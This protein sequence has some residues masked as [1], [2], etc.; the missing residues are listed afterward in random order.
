MTLAFAL[1]LACGG[2]QASSDG[3]ETGGTGGTSGTEDTS[4]TG[5][6]TTEDGS[7]SFTTSESE[8]TTE[9]MKFDVGGIP[10]VKMVMTACPVDLGETATTNGSTPFGPY[11]GKYAWY[12]WW[13]G[14]CS[15]GHHIVITEEL[16]QFEWFV[17]HHEM[18]DVDQ[19]MDGLHITLTDDS[20]TQNWQG[21]GPAQFRVFSGAQQHEL[22]GT[23]TITAID[24]FP[25]VE[26]DEN[27]YPMFEGTFDATG[28]GWDLTG[29]FTA[30]WCSNIT[31]LC[32]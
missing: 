5:T 29:T 25:W 31:T 7:S 14:E 8:S 24:E 27:P 9:D 2:P 26:P 19:L 4:T 16:D 15:G 32:P 23:V 13:G 30:P 11:D 21:T 12:G 3:G 17:T 20:W 18:V 22:D 28:N 6:G 10:D 1:S